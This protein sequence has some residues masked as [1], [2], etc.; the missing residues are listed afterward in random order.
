M[1]SDLWH[2]A[3][4]HGTAGA[5]LEA[6]R[7]E[8]LHVNAQQQCAVLQQLL[9]ISCS[10]KTLAQ[11]LLEVDALRST[12]LAA[13][14]GEASSVEKFLSLRFLSVLRRDVPM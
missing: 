3:S 4:K 11:F 8:F 6:L 14:L 9:D 1:S 5:I 13:D 2:R 10:G 7:A 12:L